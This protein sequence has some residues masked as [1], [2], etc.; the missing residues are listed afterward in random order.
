MSQAAAVCGDDVKDACADNE[1][2]VYDAHDADDF[3]GVATNDNNACDVK[4]LL[5]IMR[6]LYAHTQAC[7]RFN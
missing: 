4:L 6:H 7:F 2:N 3:D 1:E 5:T